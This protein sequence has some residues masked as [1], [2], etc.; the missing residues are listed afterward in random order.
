MKYNFFVLCETGSV[1]TVTDEERKDNHLVQETQYPWSPDFG[2]LQYQSFQETDTETQLPALSAI[3]LCLCRHLETMP[4]F[5]KALSMDEIIN[6]YGTL[7]NENLYW[8]CINIEIERARGWLEKLLPIFGVIFNVTF[9]VCL[10]FF[11]LAALFITNDSRRN[12]T[13]DGVSIVLTMLSLITSILIYFFSEARRM[14]ADLGRYI[15]NLLCRVGNSRRQVSTTS[16]SGAST[17]E[18]KIMSN[19]NACQKNTAKI[20]L[21]L[22]II[23]VEVLAAVT[24]YQQLLALI[25]KA[26]KNDFFVIKDYMITILWIYIIAGGISGITFS[27]SFAY[28]ASEK[29]DSYYEREDAVSSRT[30]YQP[31]Y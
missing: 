25:E 28:K 22:G 10:S 31:I 8:V 9:A 30:S 20:S 1:S 15:D 17:T 5:H 6:K 2:T 16:T 23:L 19:R 12:G 21:S 26:D 29:I 14:L 7:S 4:A 11:S 18:Q 24:N 3:K 27:G 13:T